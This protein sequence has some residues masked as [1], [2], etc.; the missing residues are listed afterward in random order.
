MHSMEKG[1]QER[2]ERQLVPTHG[3][4]D[5]QHPECCREQLK[6]AFSSRRPG[7]F[8]NVDVEGI[9]ASK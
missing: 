4:A 8:G 9:T 5:W 7:V 2:H 6:A 3:R 1:A